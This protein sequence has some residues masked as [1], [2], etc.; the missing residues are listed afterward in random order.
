MTRKITLT[1]QPSRAVGLH[2]VHL[3]VQKNATEP[4]AWR[5]RT[6]ARGSIA[7]NR[8]PPFDSALQVTVAGTIYRD[9][10]LSCSALVVKIGS[11][12]SS[13]VQSTCLNVCTGHGSS[14]PTLC[15][16]HQRQTG[17]PLSC[18]SHCLDFTPSTVFMHASMS[19]QHRNTICRTDGR[20][21]PFKR[22]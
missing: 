12:L 2:N 20:Y 5:S 18:C 3:R 16:K 21:S 19:S 13:N 10:F 15:A 9:K 1:M 22:R 7:K 6:C 11:A 17:I 4:C 14:Q 8:S